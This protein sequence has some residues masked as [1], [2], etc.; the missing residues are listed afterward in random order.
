MLICQ[1]I[2]Q[3]LKFWTGGLLVLLDLLLQCFSISPKVARKIL[4]QL[5]T[6]IFLF[7]FGVGDFN[8]CTL[9]HALT[10]LIKIIY[11]NFDCKSTLHYIWTCHHSTP[12]ITE[13]LRLFQAL[14]GGAFHSS[15]LFFSFSKIEHMMEF[16]S[17]QN[18]YQ[19]Q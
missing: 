15:C 5:L 8:S 11:W 18:F 14:F 17:T 10:S 6:L 1:F 12:F 13:S 7:C 3:M 19:M 16:T 9:T 2:G 4:H